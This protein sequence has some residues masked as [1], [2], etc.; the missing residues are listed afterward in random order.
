MTI[1]IS[2][3]VPAINGIEIRRMGN[4]LPLN[5]KR[6]ARF[7]DGVIYV[8]PSTGRLMTNRTGN[9]YNMVY[10]RNLTE[11]YVRELVGALVDVGKIT[12]G[13]AAAAIEENRVA[14]ARKAKR[15]AAADLERAAKAL[16]LKLTKHQ[17]KVID[18][19]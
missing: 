12:K 4:R 14:Q 13:D 2:S 10:I 16:G 8:S 11:P 6:L 3:S 7:W 17:Q 5:V 19:A 15:Y 1:H 18:Q 9:N